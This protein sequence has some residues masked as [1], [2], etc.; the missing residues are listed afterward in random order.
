MGRTLRTSVI[1][2]AAVVLAAGCTVKKTTVPALAGP[3]ELGLS[4]SVTANPDVIYQDAWSHSVITIV[5]RNADGTAA[6]NVTLQ[7]QTSMDGVVADVGTLTNKRPVTGGDGRATVTYTGPYSADTITRTVAIEVTPVGTDY[8]NSSTYRSV[9]ILL[10]PAGTVPP[11][12]TLVA[13]F[14]ITPAT[15]PTYTWVVFNAPAC[16]TDGETGCTRGAIVSYAWDFGDGTTGAGQAVQHVFTRV[17]AYAVTL[18]V[19]GGI[20]QTASATKVVQVTQ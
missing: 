16:T 6:P 7:L 14:T 10:L 11:P 1:L 5:A 4:L 20:G 9:Q 2:L 8:A 3:S 13:G 12:S 19:T 18:T 15:V 17:G